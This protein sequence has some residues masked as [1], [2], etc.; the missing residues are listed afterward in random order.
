MVSFHP[1]QFHSRSCSTGD[2]FSL[3][4]GF[5]PRLAMLPLSFVR[6]CLGLNYS[7][8]CFFLS[9]LPGF[10]HSGSI[11]CA[12]IFV[13]RPILAY[14]FPF[15]LFPCLCSTLVLSFPAIPFPLLC[16]TSQV[17]RSFR[18]PVSSS[19]VPLSFR[20]RFRYSGRACTLKTEHRFLITLQSLKT[21]TE[22][23]LW[24]SFRL[25]SISQLHT[26]L[27]FHL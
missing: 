7:A 3:P 13:N 1:T 11:R 14:L 20:L 8:F 26:L 23:A 17:L 22:P 5:L 16:F 15:D 9:L 4:F 19:V 2:R 21:F 25:I 6:F 27:R 18:P 10:P 24:S 12:S